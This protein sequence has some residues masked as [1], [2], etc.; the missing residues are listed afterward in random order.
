M[1]PTTHVYFDYYQTNDPAETLAIGG[2]TPLDKTYSFDPIPEE[3][4]AEQA[5]Y[6]KGT[7]GTLWSEY[8]PTTDRLEY[9][10]FPRVIALSEV[11]W[12]TPEQRDFAS[13]R[14][15]LAHHE[16]RLTHLNVSFRPVATWEQEQSFGERPSHYR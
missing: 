1:A 11:A 15:R 9:M 14:Q 6:V 2:Y 13:F 8:I 7:E 12:S 3:L 10:A 4:T 5:R 16:A